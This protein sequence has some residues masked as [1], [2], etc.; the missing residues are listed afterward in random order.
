MEAICPHFVS[1]SPV[2]HVLVTMDTLLHSGEGT[3]GRDLFV[4]GNNYNYQLGMGKRG[5]VPVPTSLENPD[6]S[7]FML[8][9]KKAE[10]VKDLQGRVWKKGVYVEQRAVALR[11]S[12]LVYW[13]I[14][15]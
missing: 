2:G 8:S 1:I 3:G 7:R 13:R 6:G 5:S 10:V 9:V 12:S 14:V 15:R 4:W 11:G